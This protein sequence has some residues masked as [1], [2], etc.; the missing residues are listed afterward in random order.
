[1]ALTRTI[2]L[3]T[4]GTDTGPFNLYSDTD[5]YSSAFD[6][7]ISKSSLVGGYT[8]TTIPLETTIV[9]VK[10]T[11]ACTNYIDLSLPHANL[12]WTFYADAPTGEFFI[13]VN[14][15]PTVHEYSTTQ[16]TSYSGNII[17]YEGDIIYTQVGTGGCTG[18]P[19]GGSNAKASVTGIIVDAVCNSSNPSVVLSPATYTITSGDIGNN[20]IL[21]A[22]SEC[23]TTC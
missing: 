9:R 16:Y 3:T 14:A 2:T 7:S 17:V 23:G 22:N 4:A 5:S 21:T 15:A 13:T 11:G 20:L 10:S 1:M 18:A 8:T 19:Y 12:S 6:S